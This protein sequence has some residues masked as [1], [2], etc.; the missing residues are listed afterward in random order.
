MEHQ[1]ICQT[2]IDPLG[3]WAFFPDEASALQYAARVHGKLGPIMTRQQAHDLV[4]QTA[5][6]DDG[7]GF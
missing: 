5:P 6:P 3:A 4:A 7:H 1:E 2:V